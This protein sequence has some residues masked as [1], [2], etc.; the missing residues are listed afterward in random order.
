VIPEVQVTRKQ[1]PPLSLRERERQKRLERT[2]WNITNSRTTIKGSGKPPL[3]KDYPH[4]P[5]R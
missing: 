4:L 1:K 2:G 3:A 5:D